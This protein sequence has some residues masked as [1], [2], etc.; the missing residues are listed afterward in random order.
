MVETINSYWK[1]KFISSNPNPLEI[2]SVRFDTEICINGGFE[3][4]MNTYNRYRGEVDNHWEKCDPTRNN[5][6]TVWE[7]LPVL[8]ATYP[9]D[10]IYDFQ[11][12]ESGTDYNIPD[13]FG[14]NKVKFDD[15]SLRINST[16]KNGFQ[17]GRGKWG[18]NK[19]TKSFIVDPQHSK[20]GIWYSC[21]L[22]DPLGHSNN[23]N[24]NGKPYFNIQFI[25]EEGTIVEELCWDSTEDFF[26]DIYDDILDCGRPIGN[27]TLKFQPWRCSIFDLT[28][29]AGQSLM[30]EI[31]TA[32]CGKGGHFGYAYIDGICEA[33]AT[34]DLYFSNEE[35]DA[36]QVCGSYDLA[37]G[38]NTALELVSME[39]T[40]SGNLGTMETFPVTDIDLINNSFCIDIPEN[41]IDINEC[42]D[43]RVTGTF[44]DNVNAPFEVMSATVITGQYNDFCGDEYHEKLPLEYSVSEVV[45]DNNGTYAYL[46]DDAFSFTLDIPNPNGLDWSVYKNTYTLLASGTGTATINLGPFDYQDCDFFTIVNELSNTVSYIDLNLPEDCQKQCVNAIRVCGHQIDCDDNG[47][48]GFAAD[49]TWTFN[50]MAEGQENGIFYIETNPPF[51][52]VYNT[53][54]SIDMGLMSMANNLIIL[55]DVANGCYLEYEIE[56]P[57]GCKNCNFDLEFI[58][59]ACT[60]DPCSNGLTVDIGVIDNSYQPCEL[61]FCLMI[62]EDDCLPIEIAYGLSTTINNNGIPDFIS[63]TLLDLVIQEGP[64]TIL[65]TDCNGCTKEYTIWPPECDDSGK[66][67]SDDPIFDDGNFTDSDDSDELMFYFNPNPSTDQ[68]TLITNF[69]DGY[70]D[71]E[72]YNIYGQ[73]VQDY[74]N[75]RGDQKLHVAD[76]DIGIYTIVVS[77][78]GRVINTSKILK[79]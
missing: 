70:Y 73:K 34:I 60:P 78:K 62:A 79:I 54:Y 16:T 27:D 28:P 44:D 45:C 61:E 67:N 56:V 29:Y 55:E 40:L 71:L 24:Y 13:S 42:Y 35:C 69:V 63:Y 20:F 51:Y 64:W 57:P 46:N 59:G 76:F 21:L 12:Q 10:Y 58:V 48:P 2:Q 31:V 3:D 30:M 17:C 14:F 23:Y 53:A 1:A 7:Y 72:I 6:P 26:Y 38:E 5:L 52:G 47:T 25:D 32:D 4:A 18:I 36:I 22:Q 77:S 37:D 49:D 9:D 19:I 75:L 43:I 8:P 66:P 15:H 74:K 50:F 68:L 11:I 33:C 39:A 41:L 65:V